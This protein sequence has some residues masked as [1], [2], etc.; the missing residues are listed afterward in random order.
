[1]LQGKPSLSKNAL[2]C[3]LPPMPHRGSKTLS[4]AILLPGIGY[5]ILTK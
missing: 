1:M 4:E 2:T 3:I 5:P